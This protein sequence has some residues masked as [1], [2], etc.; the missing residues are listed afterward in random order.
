MVANSKCPTIGRIVDELEYRLPEEV[1][2]PDFVAIEDEDHR[3]FARSMFLKMSEK[4]LS[5]LAEIKKE[6][7]TLYALIE[8]ASFYVIWFTVLW[9]PSITLP[10]YCR[11]VPPLFF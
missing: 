10:L 4:H 8:M 11:H 5:I 9:T 7:P 1:I 3:F 2:R 6:K